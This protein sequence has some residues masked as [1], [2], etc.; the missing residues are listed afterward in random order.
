MNIGRFCSLLALAI[1]ASVPATSQGITLGQVDTFED[2][3]SQGWS[4]SIV[5]PPTPT[6]GPAGNSDHYFQ[7]ITE[8]TSLIGPPVPVELQTSNIS[9][10]AGNYLAAGVTGVEMD[11]KNNNTFGGN[12]FIR[13]AINE[14]KFTTMSKMAGYSST[15]AFTLPPDGQWYHAVFSLDTGS[16]TPISSP[17]PLASDLANVVDFQIL[18]SSSPSTIGDFISFG[19]LGIDNV[20]AVPEPASISILI[21]GIVGVALLR[22]R[23]GNQL[24]FAA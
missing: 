20:H 19:A 13:I 7:L 23:C 11:L 9:Q 21:S 3:T 8:G 12:L 10:W 15:T 16:L 4:G 1:L 14:D 18:N 6:G 22:R 5:V 24:P 2:G 17:Q